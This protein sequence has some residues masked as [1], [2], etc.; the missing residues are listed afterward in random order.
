MA[1]PFFS[2]RTDLLLERPRVAWLLVK[3]PIRLGNGGGPHEARGVE[4][5]HRLFA[6]ALPDS[7][8]HPCCIHS[9]IDYQMRDVDILRP[10]FARGAL[11]NRAQAEFRSR[12][13]RV[14]DSAADTRRRS[15]KENRSAP[16][17]Q[18]HAR[19]LPARDKPGI[20]RHFPHL[21]EDA[22]RGLE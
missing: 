14:S 13:C 2:E 8:A 3:L 11:R 9:R 20:A 10:E 15:R 19:R 7:V 1:S 17:R 5:L 4:V 16:A 21:A 6:F 12:K 22:V 18:H